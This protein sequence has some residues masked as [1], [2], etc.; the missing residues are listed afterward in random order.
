MELGA[1][2]MLES[3]GEKNHAYVASV[4]N[5]LF[6]FQMIEEGLKIYV[7]LSYEVISRSVPSPVTFNFDPSAINSAPLGR[8]IKLFAGISAHA[9]LTADL[10][11]IEEWRN[12]C[13]HRAYVHEFMSRQCDALVSAKDVLDVQTITTFAVGLL[14]QIGDDMRT[15]REVHRALFGVKNESLKG[16]LSI[17]R[18]S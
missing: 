11:K 16:N 4:H 18:T 6:A 12:F 10:R 2:A 8:L 1:K 13:A 7:G 3:V 17:E 15:L 14:N 9:R 5:A